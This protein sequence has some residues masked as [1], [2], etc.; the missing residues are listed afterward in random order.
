MQLQL[1]QQDPGRKDESCCKSRTCLIYATYLDIKSIQVSVSVLNHN[2]T[3]S[4][5]CRLLG[6]VLIHT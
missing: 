5:T 6:R 1:Y 4:A 3:I 2:H